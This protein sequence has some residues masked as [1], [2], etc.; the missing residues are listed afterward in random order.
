MYRQ[1]KFD[2]IIMLS[3]HPLDKNSLHITLILRIVTVNI[4]RLILIRTKKRTCK[5]HCITD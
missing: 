2:V 1:Y 5:Q 4:V 3:Y